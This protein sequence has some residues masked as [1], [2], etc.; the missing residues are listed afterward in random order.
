MLLVGIRQNRGMVLGSHV[1]L[2]SLAIGASARV[3]VHTS[4]VASDKRDGFDGR[5]V[6]NKVDGIL[7]R[8][9]Q[10]QDECTNAYVQSRSVATED[11]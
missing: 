9:S 6:A 5:V 11:A 3:N 10:L 1:G 2:H 4:L 8:W 7:K